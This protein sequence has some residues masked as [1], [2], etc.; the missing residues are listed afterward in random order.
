MHA[1]WAKSPVAAGIANVK[2]QG[3][4]KLGLLYKEQKGQCGQ[5][6]AWLM[7]EGITGSGAGGH[8]ESDHT[9]PCRPRKA[10]GLSLEC[11]SGKPP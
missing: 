7:R 1:I 10:G 9:K 11:C 2:S 5:S 6:L 8:Q 4:N 3:G